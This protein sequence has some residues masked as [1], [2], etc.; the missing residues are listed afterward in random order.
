G[1]NSVVLVQL[2]LKRKI[3]RFFAFLRGLG[4]SIVLRRLVFGRISPGGERRI[5]LAFWGEKRKFVAMYFGRISIQAFLVLPFSGF[6]APFDID[7][8][9]F[10]QVF[11][12]NFGRFVAHHNVVPFGVAHPIA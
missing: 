1:S 5:G 9:A 10:S 8:V 6:D 2:F 3:V 12:A 4:G 11:F 7:F